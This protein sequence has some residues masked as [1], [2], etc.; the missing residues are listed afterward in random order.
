MSSGYIMCGLL[1]DP[2]DDSTPEHPENEDIQ[3]TTRPSTPQTL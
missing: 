2:T 1:V 3:P